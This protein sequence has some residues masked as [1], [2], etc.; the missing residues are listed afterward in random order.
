MPGAPF[1]E[2]LFFDMVASQRP[3]PAPNLQ[4]SAQSFHLA[5][6]RATKSRVV[7][8]K[9]KNLACRSVAKLERV[10]RT[11]VVGF[12]ALICFGSICR[13]QSST[14]VHI[15]P[16]DKPALGGADS[17]TGAQQR[18]PGRVMRSSFLSVDVDLVLVPVTVTDSMNRPVTG[19]SKND[20]SI[21]ED[22]KPQRIRYFS[23]EDSPI[24][25]GILLDVSG[26]MSNKI[27]AAR[28]A[29]ADFF[30]NAHPDDDYFVITFADRPELLAD[31]TRS[32]GD[33][34]ASLATVKP[35]GY[36]ALLDA[37]HMGLGKLQTA[38]YQRRALLIISDG[39]DNA[40]RH[41]VRGV[42]SEVEE[43]D[44]E[45]YAIGLFGDGLPILKRFD[46]K[47]G[48]RLLCDMTEA[49][50][51]RT[52]T[53]ENAAKLSDAAAAISTEMR[54][55]YLLGYRPTKSV[56][57]GK[58][59]KIRVRVSPALA[60]RDENSALHPAYRKGYMAPLH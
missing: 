47:L 57:N 26:T 33:I 50:G 56:R 46:E 1:H 23:T 40:S 36:T 41:K 37:I 60:S 32:I 45:V 9:M 3:P 12:L 28:E 35:F 8:G 19:L 59:R 42:R 17:E 4:L 39:G 13:A 6:S 29:L 43:S 11:A 21:Y 55:Q 27:D 14:D 34:R 20:F 53:V 44:V 38:R 24:S 5:D 31:S 16:R 15:V 25:V 18:D 10:G 30:K 54:S 48:K 52:I 7:R 49:S 2:L 58:W 22:D 51:G